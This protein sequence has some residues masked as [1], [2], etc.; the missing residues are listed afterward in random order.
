MPCQASKMIPHW[1]LMSVCQFNE[2]YVKEDKDE[3]DGELCSRIAQRQYQSTITCTGKEELVKVIK[4]GK[5]SA[6][7]QKLVGRR[8]C[9]L[10][11]VRNFELIE[12]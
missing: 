4:I 2:D 12:S 5:F 6:K 1:L 3:L 9:E 7:C 8:V 10:K 11:Q